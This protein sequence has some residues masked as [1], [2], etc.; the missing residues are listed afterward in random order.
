MD[1]NYQGSAPNDTMGA[2][3]SKIV[4]SDYLRIQT[5]ATLKAGSLEI[6]VNNEVSVSGTM[7]VSG[8]GFEASTGPGG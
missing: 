5:S 8:G 3:V 2:P 7:D 1:F 6:L 4:M